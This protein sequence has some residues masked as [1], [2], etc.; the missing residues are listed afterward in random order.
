MIGSD[1][2]LLLFISKFCAKNG[3]CCRRLKE[4][5]LGSITDRTVAEGMLFYY[6]PGCC[7]PDQMLAVVVLSQH[8]VSS[9]KNVAPRG[10]CGA[11]CMGNVIRTWFGI[12][13]EAPQFVE[14][15]RLDL[16]IDE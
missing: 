10:P 13:L 6:N 4:H 9:S 8:R 16:C 11:Q 7:L 2:L 14:G 5:P 3:C 12:C 15:A 1:E